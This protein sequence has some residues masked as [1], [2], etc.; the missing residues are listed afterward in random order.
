MIWCIDS[1][2]FG[3]SEMDFVARA[4]YMLKEGDIV[5]LSKDSNLALQ[6][7]IKYHPVKI[8]YKKAGNNW[9]TIV[10]NFIFFITHCFKYRKSTFL[11]WSHHIDSNRW[12]QLNVSIFRFKFVIVE[13]SM[14]KNFLDFNQ[15]K[16]SIPIKRF[17]VSRSRENIV[18]G[19]SQVSFYREL[20]KTDNCTAIPNSREVKKIQAEVLVHKQNMYFP[21]NY[22]GF[23]IVTIGRLCDHKDQLSI[24]HAIAILKEKFNVSLIVV[25][26]GEKLMQLQT[27]VEHLKLNN[28]YFIG[29]TLSPIEWLAKAD[30]F[31]L[32]SQIEG[33]PGVLIEAMAAKVPCIAT[34]I[35][36][37]NEL[38]IQDKT[39]LI[40]NEKS[41]EELANAIEYL[42]THPT[43]ATEMA[44]NAY[45]HVLRNY[46]FDIEK[47]LWTALLNKIDEN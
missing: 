1:P 37:N 17:I 45:E 10:P 5:I 9:R 35:R 19:Y 30:I 8:L 7:A 2:G 24:I 28:V 39:G 11:F 34:N 15:S 40:V 22:P 36:G 16:L 44:A 47:S 25:G 42:Y 3:G 31:I 32:N 46:D 14:P 26:A 21:Q 23:K 6:K 38:I 4:N 20:F 29:F 43:L 27:A 33:L 41:P 18:C 12:L 13:R